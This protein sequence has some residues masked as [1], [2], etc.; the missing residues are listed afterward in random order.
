MTASGLA[1]WLLS[2]GLV[3]LMIKAISRLSIRHFISRRFRDHSLSHRKAHGLSHACSVR[4][5]FTSR[6]GYAV[7]FFFAS[8]DDL[9][10]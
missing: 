10:A 9:A 4:N 3:M 5:H 1:S 7:I 8:A 2:F 6:C